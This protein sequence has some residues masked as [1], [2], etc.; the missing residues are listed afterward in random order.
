MVT[1]SSWIYVVYPQEARKDLAGT[2]H[3]LYFLSLLR[4]PGWREAH[5]GSVL[6]YY[7]LGFESSLHHGI[8]V[9]VRQ[10][11]QPL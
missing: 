7:S 8:S 1:G 4:C 9:D 5:G 10:I 6:R 11:L 3:V 2:G